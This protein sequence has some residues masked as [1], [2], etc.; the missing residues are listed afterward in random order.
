MSRTPLVDPFGRTLS[1]LRLSVTDRCNLR[2]V[3][4]LPALV[5]GLFAPPQELLT[6]DELI[7][8]VRAFVALGFSRFRI[9]GGEPLLRPGIVSLI[10]VFSRMDGI[11]DLSMSTNGLRLEQMAGDLAQAGLHRINI[12]LDTLCPQRFRA[13]T[14]GGSLD[15]V[16][17]GLE[18]AFRGGLDP[19][20]LNVVVM[21]GINDHEIPRFVRLTED[22]PLHVRFI[23]L[24]PIGDTGFFSKD[25]WVP[26]EEMLEKAGEG[27]IPLPPERWPKGFG[28]ARYFQRP[29]A[30]GTVGFIS[31]LS[32][33][34]CASCNR[35]RLSARGVLF[36]CLDGTD[37]VD[38]KTPLRQGASEEQIQALIC[39]A[40]RQKPEHHTMKERLLSPRCTSPRLMCQM[41]G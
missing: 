15:Q 28:P 12:S 9:T 13:I 10:R 5:Q 36:T 8:L 7:V 41:G 30:P 16:L 4:C 34:F 33:G 35:V 11:A 29:G 31:A 1:Y 40:I 14:R 22:H 27:L 32:Q 37:G 3:Y 25:R 17:C 23:E 2:C 6:D 24:M 20:K 21:R 39:Q 26:L 38:L 19:I 18:A